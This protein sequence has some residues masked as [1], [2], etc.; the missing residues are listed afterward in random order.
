MKEYLP[1]IIG[2][3]LASAVFAI[4]WRQGAFMRISTYFAETKEEL[5]KC[6]WPT[7]EELGGSTA[8]VMVSVAIIGLFTI[9]VDL[10]VTAVMKLIVA[11]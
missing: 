1:L 7:W 9:G 8:L 2:I 6:N 11:G 10:F 5:V 3:V 4:L